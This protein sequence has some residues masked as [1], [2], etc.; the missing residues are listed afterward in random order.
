MKK[1]ILAVFMLIVLLSSLITMTVSAAYVYNPQKAEID[2]AV[3]FEWVLVDVL[4]YE[5][6]SKYYTTTNSYSPNTFSFSYTNEDSSASSVSTF[7]VP[8][9]SFKGGDTIE[10]DV[11]N[12]LTSKNRKSDLA[13]NYSSQAKVMFGEYNLAPDKTAANTKLFAPQDGKSGLGVGAMS[14]DATE[15]SAKMIAVAPYGKDKGAKIGIH[16][17][18][19]GVGVMQTT[20]VYEWKDTSGDRWM[21]VKTEENNVDKYVSSMNVDHV[22]DKKHVVR[23]HT[24]AYTKG[25]ITDSIKWIIDGAERYSQVEF[26]WSAPPSVIICGKESETLIAYGLRFTNGAAGAWSAANAQITMRADGPNDG[27][28]TN[29]TYH[30]FSFTGASGT[31]LNINKDLYSEADNVYPNGNVTKEKV[32]KENAVLKIYVTGGMYGGGATY[33]YAFVPKGAAV[34]AVKVGD[35]STPDK[36]GADVVVNT[37]ATN[38]AGEKGVSVPAIIAVGILG[39]VVALSG[40]GTSSK[41]NLDNTEEDKNAKKYKMYI[42]KNFGDSIR[43]DKPG[44]P[45]YARMVEILNGEETDRFDL[46]QKIELFSGS[47]VI[48]VRDPSVS[49]NYVGAFVEA[50]S[51]ANGENPKEGVVSF[52]FSGE[53]GTFQ[54]NVKFK[55]VGE[56]Y[57]KFDEQGDSLFMQ[58]N[59][60]EGDDA[61]YIVPF[62][63]FDF[64]QVPKVGAKPQDESPFAVE[65]EKID[66]YKYKAKIKN[67][68]AKSEKANAQSKLFSVEVT[69][70]SET[71]YKSNSLRAVI[72]PEGLTVSFIKFDNEGYAQ[73]GAYADNE[74]EE[75]GEDVLATRMKLE[76]AVSSVDDN[77]RTKAELV[78]LSKVE[79][80]FDKLKSQDTQTENLAK[81]FKYEIEDTDKPEIF[82]FQ[83]KMQIPEGRTKHYLSL[84]ISCEYQNKPYSLDLDVRLIGEPFNEMKEKK[85]EL[86]LLLKRIRRYMP[87]EDWSRVIGSIKE[88]YNN[89]SPKEI[90]LLNRSLYEITSDKLL[91]E[92]QT[93]INYAEN[94]D[95]VIWGLEWVKWVG[96]QA[97][98][99]A[100][101]SLGGPAGPLADALLS[102]AK[103]IMIT[104]ISE[105]IWYRE[106]ISSPDA[107]L[108]G[109]NSNLLA[110]L[111]NSLMTQISSDTSVK[112]AGAILA[113]FTVVK[114]IN[115]YYNDVGPD[116]KAIG[117]YD[118]ILAGLGDLTTN[119]FKF[120]VSNKFDELVKSPK[121]K[122]YFQKYTGEWIKHF[123]DANASGWR[124][125]G[126]EVIKKYV[127]ELCGVSAAKVYTKATQVKINETA[128]GLVI[129]INIWDD[130]K[131]IN[132]SVIVSLDVMK[133]KDKLYDYIFNSMFGSFP[134]A[135]TLLN[136]PADPL[137]IIK[138]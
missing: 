44:V 121:A 52:K 7:S 122:E 78:D 45:V 54:N 119:A 80:K 115:H 16:L 53:G 43:Y 112:K 41:A 63:L 50:E 2:A 29:D 81:V 23:T 126:V 116:G 114:I 30:T 58:V 102:P 96:D 89:M 10:I 103:E 34:G 12:K 47:G 37:N 57:I 33:T 74:K 40:A 117:F 111:E 5:I 88:N 4:N 32:M 101:L 118:A 42:N 84:P 73:I 70:E 19:S 133:I 51:V 77:G 95:W 107:K 28:A 105:N 59:M 75:D 39:A 127:E 110:M 124:D 92:A 31:A 25:K 49:G 137:F 15:A 36:G 11:T 129:N 55:L 136:P 93:N 131:D 134:F 9:S 90:R 109:V 86:E 13:Y 6:T 128:G 8:P 106:G 108:R 71:E 125:K 120:I 1:R 46:T 27:Y 62:T 94:L 135:S 38:S 26:T 91:N 48:K 21:L 79:V 35:T 113:S 14:K 83:P 132:N 65:L 56:P 100:V 67:Q 18:A 60:I 61:E 64:T 130:P 3:G 97:F 85:E 66:D 69:A 98:S 82:K 68:S 87:P 123:L 72:Y 24:H 20:Y 76:L 99:Y 138:K 104:L 17:Y 22:V